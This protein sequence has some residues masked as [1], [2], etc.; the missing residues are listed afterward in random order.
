MSVG[1]AAE[2]QREHQE[3]LLHRV[4]HSCTPDIL[5]QVIERP[6]SPEVTVVSSSVS[7]YSD[8]MPIPD[9]ED[10]R[11]VQFVT[12]NGFQVVDEVAPEKM[13]P[14][15]W[16]TWLGLARAMNFEYVH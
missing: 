1:L 3:E 14:G 7:A 16:G 10:S 12:G 5:R 2:E 4:K 8:I 11:V 9:G 13:A 15:E 6:L